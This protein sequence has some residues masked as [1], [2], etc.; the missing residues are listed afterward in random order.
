MLRI[1]SKVTW[2]PV[3]T[4]TH[5]DKVVHEGVVAFEEARDGGQPRN[6]ADTPPL[7]DDED[8]E[9]DQ[10]NCEQPAVQRRYAVCDKPVLVCA[11]ALICVWP[12]AAL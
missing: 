8:G 6:G 11:W 4:M 3:A 7:D 2:K 12:L 10:E 1:I 9:A 5:E